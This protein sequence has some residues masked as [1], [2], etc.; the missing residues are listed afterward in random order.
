MDESSSSD[1]QTERQRPLPTS[2]RWLEIFWVSTKLGLTSFGGPIAHLGYFREEYVKRRGWLD[3]RSYAELVALCQFLPGPASSQVGMGIGLMR[4]GLIGSLLA[5]LG[6]TLPSVIVMIAFAVIL[7]NFDATGAG[8][9]HGLKIAAVAVVAQAVTGMGRSLA[10]DRTR[11]A[12][13]ALA[14]CVVLLA[15]TVF[16]QIAVMIAAACAGILLYGRPSAADMKAYHESNTGISV[17]VGRQTAAACLILFF[18]LFALLPLLRYFVHHPVMQVLDGFYRSGALVFGG[19]HVVLP[20]LQREVLPTGFVSEADFLSGYAAAQAVPGPLFTFSAYL[21]MVGAG[22]IGALVGTIAIFLPGFLLIVGTLPFWSIISRSPAIRAV[23][24]GVN[25]AVVGMLL[26]ALY[27]PVWTS[28]IGSS[29]DFALA[30][31]L[32]VLLMFW[33]FPAWV[34]VAIGAAGGELLS[35]F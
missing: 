20:L 6:F 9:I 34:I 24:T 21:G 16:I 8:W 1:Q 29:A 27:D 35:L 5:W 23:M 12:I 13:A 4:G 18:G 15:S 28:A 3:E 22:W 25:A 19:G 31:I 30:A 32:F 11:A 33:K 2:S 26:A 10:P 7:Q 14:A 17:P